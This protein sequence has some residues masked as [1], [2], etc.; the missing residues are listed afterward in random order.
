M[1]TIIYLS[2]IIIFAI[3]IVF[4]LK[5]TKNMEREHEYNIDSITEEVSATME[6]QTSEYENML[7]NEH[8]RFEIELNKEINRFN[9]IISDKNDYINSL[10]AFSI[11]SGEVETHNILLHVK[12]MLVKQNLVQKEEMVILGNLFVP[13]NKGLELKTKQIDH[14]ILLPTGMYIIETKKWSGTVLHGVSYGQDETLDL[15]I[16]SMFPYDDHKEH[17]IVIKNDGVPEPLQ[18]NVKVIS[19]GNPSNQVI[20]TALKLKHFLE[21]ANPKY[22]FVEPIVYYNCASQ[23]HTVVKNYSNNDR[24]N[25]FTDEKSLYTF[26]LEELTT[27]N[28][29]Y[30]HEE[31]ADIT[32]YIINKNSMGNVDQ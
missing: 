20:E 21:E 19:Y 15:L 25:I 23:N 26:F 14:F 2:I 28:R 8:Q 31:L 32:S 18:A 6:T 13:Y 17:T 10:K 9:K 11:N 7:H 27:K 1:I 5:R 22:N 29:K 3:V 30:Q 16:H 4:L 12:D 24:V